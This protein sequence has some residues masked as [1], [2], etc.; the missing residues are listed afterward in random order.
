[1]ALVWEDGGYGQN[2]WKQE[3]EFKRHTDLSFGNPDWMKLAE[4]FGWT[5][6]RVSNSRDLA[7]VLEKALAE[8]GPSLVVVPID[9]RENP[10]LTERLGQITQP[11]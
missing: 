1:V 5:G 4:S 6:H 3:T 10:L 8:D 7:G 9:Y 2:A 11:L